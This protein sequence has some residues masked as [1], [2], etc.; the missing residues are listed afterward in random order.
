MVLLVLALSYKQEEMINIFPGDTILLPLPS[1][2]TPSSLDLLLFGQ[3][4]TCY[5]EVLVVKCSNI[6]KNETKVSNLADIDYNYFAPGSSVTISG[7]NLIRPYQIWLFSNKVDA[8]S[9]VK[10]QFH[11]YNCLSAADY[12]AL[13][14][15]LMSGGDTATISVTESAYY[16]IRCDQEPFDCSQVDQWLINAVTYDFDVAHDHIIHCAKV[17][18]QNTSSSKLRIRPSVFYSKYSASNLCPIAQLNTTICGSHDTIY[19][20]DTSSNSLVLEIFTYATLVIVI[21]LIVPLVACIIWC[22]RKKKETNN[23][24]NLDE[25]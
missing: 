20:I 15:Q 25:A 10:E 21:I 18:A 17:Q 22:Y 11:G 6:G 3:E 14:A 12:G 7:N 4:S 24:I 5:A 2:Y 16:Y 19:R 9:A 1:A 23:Y 8:D 13:C